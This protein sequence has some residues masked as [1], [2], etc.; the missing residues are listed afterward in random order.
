M[1]ITVFSFDFSGCGKSEGDY[2]SLGWYEKDDVK[3][4]VEYLRKSGTVSTIGLWGR[5]MGAITSLMHSDRDP[6]IAALVLDSPFASLRKVAEELAKQFSKI[7]NF[8]TSFGLMFVRKTIKNKAKFNIDHLKPIDH[9][10]KAFI[11]AFFMHA[12]DD[13][14]ILPHHSKELFEKYAG[15]KQYKL[16]EGDHNSVRPN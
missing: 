10:D 2:I 12:K 1:N 16:I 4:I 7:P 15:D 9:V 8:L 5:S 3:T 13:T 14:F 11:P 6:S